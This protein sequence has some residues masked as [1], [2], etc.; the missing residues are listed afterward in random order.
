MRKLKIG[1]LLNK[2]VDNY[3]KKISLPLKIKKD[4]TQLEMKNNNWTEK[5]DTN[6]QHIH[7]SHK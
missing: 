7:A 4:I 6:K 2:H 1:P 3:I 5:K